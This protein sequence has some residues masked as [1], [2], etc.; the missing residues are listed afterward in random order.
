[1]DI[2]NGEIMQKNA[3]TKI[4]FFQANFVNLLNCY[5]T[6]PRDPGSQPGGGNNL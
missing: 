6:M 4:A 3:K 1:M 5:N 2:L